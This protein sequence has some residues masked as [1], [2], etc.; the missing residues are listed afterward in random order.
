MSTVSRSDLYRLIDQ[1][2][3]SALLEVARFLEFVSYK[4][5]NTPPY[6]PVALGGL[7]QDLTISDEDIA[8]VRQEMWQ[9]FGDPVQ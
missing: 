6:T 3:E 8:T 9:G 7:W 1:L 2:P 4:Q 5:K